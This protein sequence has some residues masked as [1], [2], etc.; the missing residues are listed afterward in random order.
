MVNMTQP[1]YQFG[2]NWGLFIDM[3][4]MNAMDVMD[5]MDV[6]ID[7]T[8]KSWNQHSNKYVVKL[9]TIKECD[10]GWV[11]KIDV[12]DDSVA[13]LVAKYLSITIMGFVIFII[14]II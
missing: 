6:M 4:A 9:Q 8:T 10:E 1:V 11:E 5:A 12:T 2:N 13:E 3:D 7:S 14:F